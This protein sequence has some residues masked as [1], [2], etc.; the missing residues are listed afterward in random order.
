[1][2]CRWD[3]PVLC[4]DLTFLIWIYVALLQTMNHLRTSGQ[5]IKLDV[6]TKLAYVM[7]AFIL[8]VG[9]VTLVIVLAR[10][11]VFQWPWQ[12]YWMQTVLWE[13]LNLAV[14]IA[15]TVIWAPSEHAQL[16]AQS[17]QLTTDEF[18]AA[19]DDNEFDE[20]EEDDIGTMDIGDDTYAKAAE[21]G[22]VELTVRGEAEGED[23]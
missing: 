12:L 22:D 21:G 20:E 2:L 3:F 7:G 5:T 17:L 23:D 10:Q 19:V 15:I 8:L 18:D 16:L 14:L 4:F 13:V 9:M 6:Y 1:M 11:G